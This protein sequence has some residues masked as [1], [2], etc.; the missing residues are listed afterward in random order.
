MAWLF[1]EFLTLVTSFHRPRLQ[2]FHAPPCC[3]HRLRLAWT[4]VLDLLKLPRLL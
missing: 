2:L 1:S 3:Y 4:R